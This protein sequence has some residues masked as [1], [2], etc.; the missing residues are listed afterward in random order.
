MPTSVKSR[1]PPSE[2][3]L[4]VSPIAYPA[5]CAVIVSSATSFG[6]FGRRPAATRQTDNGPW[7]TVA[8]NVGAVGRS[9]GSPCLSITTAS[10]CT[11]ACASATP[12]TAATCSSTSTGSRSRRSKPRNPSTEFDDC[13]YPSTR[14]KTFAN[15]ALKVRCTVSRNM[16]VPL[17]NA[18]LAT[19]A[20][21]VSTTRP[22]RARTLRN[23]RRIIELS[24]PSCGCDGLDDVNVGG[25]VRRNDGGDH[26]DDERHD[27]D[28]D[29]AEHGH[30]EHRYAFVAQR[31]HEQV[32]A[33]EA[34][35]DAEHRAEQTRDDT[36][37]ADRRPHL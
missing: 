26:P 24:S 22:Q 30:R 5:S 7:F 21:A 2:L 1:E 17:R 3:T 15:N 32:P 14:S 20:S 31:Q 27:E 13:T 29:R 23:A 36:L 18:V 19:I 34:E 37:P 11:N 28:H 35:N 6:P 9:I 33:D 8:P 16:K 4:T 12:S 10:P 25:A